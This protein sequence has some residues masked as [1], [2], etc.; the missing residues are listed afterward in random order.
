MA[1]DRRSAGYAFGY[2]DA[3]TSGWSVTSI[4]LVV[5]YSL[6]LT[7]ADYGSRPS[8]W[9]FFVGLLQAAYTLTGQYSPLPILCERAFYQLIQGTGWLPQCARKSKTQSG[10]SPRPW[11]SLWLQLVS[12]ASSSVGGPRNSTLAPT[13]LGDSVV[14]I[15][16]VLPD[17]QMLLA[18]PSGQPIGL[19]FKT[20]TGSAAGGFGLLFLILGVLFF[21]GVGALTAA[22]RCTYA[23][24]RD[25]AIPGS[26]LW[27]K[28]N[29]RLDV[30]L[31]GIVLSTVIDC[32]LGLLYFGST[33]A[34]NSFTGVA[35][36]CLATSY[37]VP[38]LISLLRGRRLVKHS[39]FSLG[40]FGFIIN[41]ITIIWIA[42]AIVLFC[43]PISIPVTASTMNYASAVFAMFA[44]VSIAWYFIRGRKSFSGP[45]V[46]ADA[47]PADIGV[48]A[49]K[50][51]TDN[52][53]LPV[54]SN[55]EK[56]VH[57]KHA[58]AHVP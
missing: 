10:R 3:S 6:G 8:G 42:F 13:D 32:L 27:S 11:C 46:Q 35:T 19:L 14:P 57:T 22:S 23:F 39:P 16:F 50:T 5:D 30:P 17:V 44:S 53:S 37:G 41:L 7:R 25:G 56:H 12:L 2:F 36:I 38:I 55:E 4:N 58:V 40:K 48:V 31:W 52:E 51:M 9:S 20:V 49:G 1:K 15:L 21:A 34:F 29:H 54:E 28:V 47:D 18:V 24:S 33:A 45:P 26:R 43:M